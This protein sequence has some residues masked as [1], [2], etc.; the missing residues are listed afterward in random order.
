MDAQCQCIKVQ[1]AVACDYD[2]AVED[3]SLRQ[4]LE[5]RFSQLRKVAVERLAITA[6]DEQLVFPAKDQSA[7][8]VP[9]RLKNPCVC[10]GRNLINPFGEHRQNRRVEGEEDAGL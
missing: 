7:E 8:S 10:I 6:L 9:L 2:L 1:A 5:Q 4:L 3:A